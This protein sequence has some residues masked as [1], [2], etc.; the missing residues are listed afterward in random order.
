MVVPLKVKRER[1]R[2]LLSPNF[3]TITPFFKW[4]KTR[5]SGED[6]DEEVEETDS[7]EHHEYADLFSA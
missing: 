5:P 6:E 4:T 3:G 1:E 7:S 2:D